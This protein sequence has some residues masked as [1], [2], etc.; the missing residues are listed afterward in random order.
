MLI[1]LHIFESYYTNY[2]NTNIM[3]KKNILGN[4]SYTFHKDKDGWGTDPE[5]GKLIG[6][7]LRGIGDMIATIL[8]AKKK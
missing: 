3:G 2:F 1:A 7:I 8:G 5:D 4:N 6:D